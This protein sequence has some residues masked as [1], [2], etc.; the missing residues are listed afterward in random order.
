MSTDLPNH[1]CDGACDAADNIESYADSAY[2]EA[3]SAEQAVDNAKVG[4]D[5]LREGIVD[6]LHWVIEAFEEAGANK[7]CLN[8]AMVEKPLAALKDI[9]KVMS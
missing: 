2:S 1:L 8:D 6:S 3:D 7:L 4:L 5:G 9:V